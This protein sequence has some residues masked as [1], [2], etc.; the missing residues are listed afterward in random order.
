MLNDSVKNHWRIIFSLSLLKR[1]LF[2]QLLPSHVANWMNKISWSHSL[3]SIS[4]YRF[5]LGIIWIYR[6]CRSDDRIRWRSEEETECNGMQTDSL[7]GLSAVTI[8]AFYLPQANFEFRHLTH[9]RVWHIW[10]LSHCDSSHIV[11]YEQTPSLASLHIEDCL[12]FRDSI[13]I[14]RHVESSSDDHFTFQL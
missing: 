6:C 7:V 8:T 11:A 4:Y 3:W 10:H 9:L 14:L 1:Q 2:C 5:C 13:C 12:Q